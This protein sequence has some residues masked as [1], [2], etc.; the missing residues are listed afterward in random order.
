MDVRVDLNMTII[1]PLDGLQQ[2][3]YLK[4]FGDI[5]KR[6]EKRLESL[7]PIQGATQ[8]R[9]SSCTA[10]ALRAWHSQSVDCKSLTPTQGATTAWIASP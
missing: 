8:Q 2:A 10:C 7:T 4:E 9:G 6:R 1:R 3:E 5:Y